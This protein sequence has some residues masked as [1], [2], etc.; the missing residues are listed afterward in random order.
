[1]LPNATKGRGSESVRQLQSVSDVTLMP[2]CIQPHRT[3]SAAGAENYLP[4][5]FLS[6]RSTLTIDHFG[7]SCDNDSNT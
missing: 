7:E 2:V 5:F 6:H 1:M 3:L 4:F